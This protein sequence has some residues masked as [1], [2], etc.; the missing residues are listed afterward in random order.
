MVKR[1][2]NKANGY[3]N[4]NSTTLSSKAFTESINGMNCANSEAFA[5]SSTRSKEYTTSSVV[6]GLPSWK[7]APSLNVT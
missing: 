6:T 4:L 5:G 1:S 3:F 7:T 2:L